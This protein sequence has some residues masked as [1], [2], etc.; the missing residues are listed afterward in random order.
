[1]VFSLWFWL[2]VSSQLVQ[3]ILKHVHVSTH[4]C[5]QYA[6]YRQQHQKFDEL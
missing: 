3:I 1:M 4:M 2:K 5:V 6:F